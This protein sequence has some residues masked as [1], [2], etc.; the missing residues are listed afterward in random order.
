MYPASLEAGTITAMIG[1]DIQGRLG[2]ISTGL[3]LTSTGKTLLRTAVM[4]CLYLHVI[5][6]PTLH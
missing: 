4:I 2:E 1:A 5:I 6:L 3:P